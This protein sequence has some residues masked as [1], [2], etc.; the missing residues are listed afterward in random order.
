MFHEMF[1]DLGF[2]NKLERT[3]YEFE[4]EKKRGCIKMKLVDR[5]GMVEIERVTMEE[6]G[7]PS[8]V[9]M[10]RAALCVYQQIVKRA[11]KSDRIIA[12]CGNGNNGADGIAVARMLKDAGFDAEVLLVGDIDKGT[13]QL[14]LQYKIASKL[15][16]KF[17]PKYTLHTYNI[18]IDAMF[19]IGLNRAIF[20]E[21]QSII[22]TINEEH[23]FVYA[24]DTPSGVNVDN[25]EIMNVAVKA[26]VT[27]TFGYGKIGL[28]RY[29]ANLYVGDLYVEKIGFSDHCYDL[30]YEKNPEWNQYQTYELEDLSRYPKRPQQS[31]KGTF[32]T[33]LVVA[34]TRNMSGAAYFA[35]KSAMRM[36]AGLVKIMTHEDNRVILQTQLPE[37][38]LVTYD[39]QMMQDEY[40]VER[41]THEISEADVVI[42]GPGLGKSNLSKQILD[43]VLKTVKVP[44]VLDADGINIVAEKLDQ[45]CRGGLDD[46]IARLQ[47]LLPINTILTPHIKEFSRLTAESTVSI[48]A[49]CLD[50]LDRCTYNN[51]LV[52]VVKDARTLVAKN[53]LRYINLSGNAALATAGA[54]DVLTGIIAGILA[55]GVLEF[56]AT[57]LGVYLH[58]LT[59]NRYT[60]DHGDYAMIADDMIEQIQ[61]ILH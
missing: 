3:N 44:L 21:Y 48:M 16:V 26:N 28:Y 52:F 13:E 33:V 19:G 50:M 43:L 36:G 37:A 32:G 27:V 57:C 22:Q 55:Q 34:G 54:G 17:I 29:P 12:V 42:A 35:A 5:K 6:I 8:L 2:L 31:H 15:G 4:P 18:V 58:G 61:E 51:S 30:V 7:I 1:S 38:V 25:G 56:D 24:V 40:E 11:K 14:K 45:E 59:A 49:N 23:A 53:N 60:K 39:E 41:F 20:G 9:L 46:R 10:E 47:V